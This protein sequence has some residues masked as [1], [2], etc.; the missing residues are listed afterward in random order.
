MWVPH[1]R[2]DDDEMPNCSDNQRDNAITKMTPTNRIHPEIKVC[3]MLELIDLIVILSMKNCR[4][5]LFT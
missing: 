3:G 4:D 1:P 2:D 5:L